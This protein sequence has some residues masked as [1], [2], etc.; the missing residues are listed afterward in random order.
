MNTTRPEGPE[1]ERRA[2][3]PV[4][5]ALGLHGDGLFTNESERNQ[6]LGHVQR[7]ASAGLLASGMTHNLANLIMPMF[8]VCDLALI[9][10]SDDPEKLRDALVKAHGYAQR[11]NDF[12]K[13]FM[14]FV[15]R[16]HINRRP[17]PVE[18]VVEDALVILEPAMHDAGVSVL[19]RFDN[20]HVAMVDRTRLLQAVVNLVTNA[21]RAAEEAGTTVEVVVRGE[22]EWVSLEVCDDGPGIPDEIQDRLFEPFVQGGA[23]VESDGGDLED[24]SS[25]VR[26][27]G[28][29]LFVTKRLVEEQGGA[30]DFDTEPGVGTTFRVRL[31][32]AKR[33]LETE[34]S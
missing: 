10:A 23:S 18:K 33:E 32:P 17:V 29:G 15:R 13:I 22:R 19:R 1:A 21:L 26:R 11:A 20:T 34:G 6:W 27:T 7:L 9:R 28:L 31:E 4:P 16:D 14:E 5:R 24:R 3:D 30:I 8:G 2:S 25:L 12:L